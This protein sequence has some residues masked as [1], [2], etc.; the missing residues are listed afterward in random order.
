[1]FKTA[2]LTISTLGLLL[3]ACSEP[4]DDAGIAAAD[5]AGAAEAAGTVPT[6]ATALLFDVNGTFVGDATVTDSEGQL[7][8][9]VKM[10][11]MAPGTHAAHIHAIGV[12][13]APDFAT[14]GDHWYIGGQDMN[15]AMDMDMDMPM[16]M[17]PMGMDMGVLPDVPV[18]EDGTGAVTVDLPEAATMSGL[19]DADGASLIVH[20]GSTQPD[21]AATEN[22]DT[23]IV[24]GVFAPGT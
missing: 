16:D 2:T 19:M 3:A 11:D 10:N 5:E 23:R 13:D 18:G 12:C 22:P 21:S 15:M 1:M 17:G 20:A 24:C 8:V 4:E 7:S 6:R 9:S 14:S